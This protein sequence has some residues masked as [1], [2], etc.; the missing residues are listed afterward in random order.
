MANNTGNVVGA[1][2]VSN[3]A[4][5]D[6]AA[7]DKLPKA[8]RAALRESSNNWSAASIR[9]V[10]RRERMRSAQ[11]VSAIVRKDR[12]LAELNPPRL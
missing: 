6:M 4:S 9:K 1:G 2:K 7:Y 11:V 8:V 5:V 10:M 12:E 3:S